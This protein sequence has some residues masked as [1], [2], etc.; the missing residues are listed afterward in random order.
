MSSLAARQTGSSV[1]KQGLDTISMAGQAHL[2]DLAYARLR[3]GFYAMP[4][5]SA[6]FAWYYGETNDDLR[7]LI[8]SGGFFCWA[9]FGWMQHRAYKFDGLTL[10]PD[11]MFARWLPR[12]ETTVIFHGLGLALLLPLV[13]QTASIELKYLFVLTL[14]A[15]MAGNATHQSPVLSVFNR[16]LTTGWHLTVLLMPWSFPSHWQFLMPLSALYGIGMYRHALA[17]HRFFVQLVWL[18]EEGARLAKSY[19]AAKDEAENALNE[20]NLFLATASHDLRQPMHA[21]SM[22]VEAI[23]QR[24]K[25]P[26]V[27]PLL[28]DLK[29]GM[30][31]M[32][33]MFNSL[34]DLSKLESGALAQRAAPVRLHPMLRDIVSLFREQASQRGLTLRLRTPRREATVWADSALLRQA[35][36]NLVHNAL[37]YTE[38]GGILIGLRQRGSTWQIEVWDTG[39]GIA[40]EDGPQIFSPYYRSQHAWRLHSAGHGL[41]LAVVARCARLMD[42]TM[43]FQSGLGKGSRFW[44]RLP[45]SQQAEFAELPSGDEV[46]LP[47]SPLQQLSGGCLVLDDD[48]QVITAW[49]ALLDGWGV[50]GKYATNASEAL[51][52]LDA[53][54][55]PEAIFC[56]QRL[57]SGES[58]FEILKALL[59]RYPQACGAMVSG[60]LHS[61]ELQEAENEGY[62]VLRKPL[63]PAQLHA[64]LS[65][66]LAR[67]DQVT[68]QVA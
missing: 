6:T 47:G 29:I 50:T 23:A 39:V 35:L 45:E 56:D 64:V 38:H 51:Q 9:I 16:F 30:G 36:V 54:F 48:P 49:K 5:V 12:I 44:L 7:V 67:A 34:L 25:E 42:A 59:N 22:L 20:K 41:G 19:K 8:W 26:A 68:Q 27:T 58:G 37:R 53:G 21:M 1:E 62:L 66:W 3:F 55:T 43:G 57:R 2:L 60:E 31:S 40:E 28:T 13:S 32:N 61:P 63:E 52:L 11:A 24:N 65:G 17:S 18:E 33:M 14:A 46:G 15:I 10:P 4:F